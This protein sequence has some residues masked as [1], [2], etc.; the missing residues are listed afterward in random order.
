MKRVLVVDDDPAV[1]KLVKDAL[2]GQYAVELANNGKQALESIHARQPDAVILDMMM[3]VMDGWSFLEACRR[4][5]LCAELPVLV[6]SSEASACDD[7]RRLGAQACVR[8]PF[9]LNTLTAAVEH[10]FVDQRQNV[11][12]AGE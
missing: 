3:P 8:K 11:M 10:L 1:R 9:D 6:V 4:E 5:P 2:Q 7:G 12:A